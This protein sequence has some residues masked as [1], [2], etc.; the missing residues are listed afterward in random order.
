MKKAETKNKFINE[1]FIKSFSDY[2][3]KIE[4]FQIFSEKIKLYTNAINISDIV[5]KYKNSFFFK[6]V[7]FIAKKIDF[8][9][10]F[11]NNI[12]LSN[13]PSFEIYQK[14]DIDYILDKINLKKYKIIIFPDFLISKISVLSKNLYKIEIEEDMHLTIKKNWEILDDYKRSLKA[15]YRKKIKNIEKKSSTLM[16]KKINYEKFKIEQLEI[17]NLFDEVLSRNKFI[18]HKFNTKTLGELLKEKIIN[19][20]GY[21]LNNK[22]VGFSSEINDSKN[23]YSYFVGFKKEL[24]KT[25]SIYGRILLDQILN[26]I[27]NKKEKLIFGRTAN[28]FKSNFGAKPIKSYNYVM[29][30]GNVLLKF[31]IKILLRIKKSKWKQRDPFNINN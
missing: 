12:F 7:I 23:I 24:N 9:I 1:D 4:Y 8:K 19:I 5:I 31:F 20:N 16:R 3:K 30:N 25:H 10:L 6:I 26:S 13:I 27:K 21:Y 2:Q 15:K 18:I 17:Q 29:I 14:I 11:L 28:E 22:I